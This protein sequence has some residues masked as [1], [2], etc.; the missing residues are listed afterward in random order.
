MDHKVVGHIWYLC[1][2]LYHCWYSWVLLD[3][4]Y[5]QSWHNFWM[6]CHSR[7]QFIVFIQMLSCADEIQP[8]HLTPHPTYTPTP[9]LTRIGKEDQV[10]C[11]IIALWWWFCPCCVGGAMWFHTTWLF[12]PMPLPTE[13]LFYSHLLS[14]YKYRKNITCE[15][16]LQFQ[17]CINLLPLALIWRS[18]PCLEH[19]NVI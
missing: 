15:N 19:W 11:A 12:L 10:V 7:A 14:G 18:A 6:K 5:I 8:T 3:L 1:A 2:Q 16:I 13:F 4:F 17:F 9:T